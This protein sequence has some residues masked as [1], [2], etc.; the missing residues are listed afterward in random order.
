MSPLRIALC[1]A[2]LTYFF[3]PSRLLRQISSHPGIASVSEAGRR[4]FGNFQ[5][6]ASN[7]T[8]ATTHNNDN[9]YS[10]SLTPTTVSA[11][12]TYSPGEC[13][14][15]NQSQGV[16]IVAACMN[17]HDTLKKSLP[18]WLAV[19]AVH[20]VVVVDW[21]SDPPLKSIVRPGRD[22]RIKLIRVNDEKS[23]V[24]SRA[25]NLG[26]NA[27]SCG[28]ILRTDCDYS[29]A[30]DV[31]SKHNV[32][33]TDSS[34]YTGN[35]RAARDTNEAHLN[36][37]MVVKRDMFFSV[38]G[39]DERIQT[40][41][42]DDE[43]LY[44]RLESKKL[45]RKNISYDHIS[46][47]EHD[48]A[49]RKQTG[50]KFAQ[51][52][53]DVNRILLDKLEPW[54]KAMQS[55]IESSTYKTL[56]DEHTT[57]STSST[58]G[59]DGGGRYVEVSAAHIPRALQLRVPREE[60]NQA[61]LLA[62]GRRLADDHRIP[63]DVM[64]DMTAPVRERLL[65]QLMRL[66]DEL[67]AAAAN[68][69]TTTM[70][71]RRGKEVPI[72]TRA[73][74]I[75]VHCQHGLGNRLRALA[76]ALAFAKNSKRVPIVLWERDAHIAAR[77][78]DL[79]EVGYPS[80]KD[81]DKA[82]NLEDAEAQETKNGNEMRNLILISTFNPKWPFVRPGDV[83]SMWAQ[84][85]LYNYMEMEEGAKKGET[86]VND[87]DKHL[88]YKGA[89]IMEAWDYTWWEAANEQLRKMVPV[90]SVRVHLTRLEQAGIRNAIGVH[91]RNKTLDHDIEDVDMFREYGRKG[92][93]EMEAWRRRSSVKTFTKEMQRI[94]DEEDTTAKFYIASDTFYVLD[95]MEQRFGTQRIMSTKRECD[96]RHAE[97]IVFAVVDLYALS[98]TRRLLGSNWSSYTEAAQRLGGVKASLSGINFGP[99]AVGP[100]SPI[101]PSNRNSSNKTTT[102]ARTTTRTAA[103]GNAARHGAAQGWGKQ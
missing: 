1:I 55:G 79:F 26:M 48:D 77:L 96:D 46:H 56:A 40:Y 64:S 91:I 15:S 81:K 103:T 84:F 29:I 8:H 10:N 7:N 97:C 93:E 68:G 60:V 2:V 66:Q 34:F 12:P 94:M 53:I 21:G 5:S 92:V 43:D 36:G 78:D 85:Q 52:Q 58:D 37:A 31:L 98:M 76:S 33:T 89:Y 50:V 86:I 24:L 67:D 27:S 25:Y 63:W 35:W 99:G 82:L 49:S 45:S 65:R 38:G 23:W 22:A 74:V 70:T 80:D 51:V 17:R 73:K 102:S 57:S 42:W 13:Q 83:Q 90:E 44:T 6:P 95:V 72:P 32:N 3:I 101:A 30:A 100:T 59:A 16:A 28:Y 20:Q 39:Y 41:G 88:Y 4:V 14:I 47:L 11:S 69:T 71:I 61:W 18:T 19:K 54:S 62:L 9:N 87:V 75:I